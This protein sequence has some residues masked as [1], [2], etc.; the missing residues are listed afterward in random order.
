ML[1]ALLV[2]GVAAFAFVLSRVDLGGATALLRAGG[3]LLLLALIPYAAQIGLDAL[4]WRTLLGALERRVRWRRLFAIRLATEA[5]LMSVPGG[6][7]VGETLKPYLL[8]RTDAVPAADTVASIGAKKCLLV[9]AQVAY[10]TVALA[11]GWGALAAHSRAIV[12]G[13][14]LP[15]IVVAAIAALIVVGLVLSATFLAGAIGERVHRLLLRVPSARFR[16]WI[17]ARRDAFAATDASFRALGA[18]PRRHLGAAFAALF[19]AWLVEAAETWLLLRLLG[20]A[21]PLDHVLIMEASV[22]FVRN[23]AFFVPA[24]LGVQDA[25]Y[26]AFLQAFGA[27]AGG[28]AA[29]AFVILKRAKELLW[30]A[31]GY[32]TL[33]VLQARDPRAP[34]SSHASLLVTT[35]AA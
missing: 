6:S 26:V 5:V 21:L 19:A 23:V 30:V 8:H 11:V 12:G 32:L 25:G 3:P 28:A 16:G 31:V 10:L 33:F 20:L 4:A 13:D 35:E 14:G 17:A 15:W 27:G 9:F 29:G 1:R 7:V 18:A 22:V 2:A 24:G 34:Q